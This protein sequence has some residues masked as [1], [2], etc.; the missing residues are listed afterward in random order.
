MT[1]KTEKM[2][3]HVKKQL[4]KSRLTQ[5]MMQSITEKYK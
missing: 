1:V 2:K 3:L 5:T 4:Q